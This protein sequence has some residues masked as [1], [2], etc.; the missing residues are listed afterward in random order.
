MK[1]TK[2]EKLAL[3]VLLILA[4]LSFL[5]AFMGMVDGR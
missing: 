1:I 5:P 4:V 2:D 3:I